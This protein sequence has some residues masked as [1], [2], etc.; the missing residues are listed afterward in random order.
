MSIC[1]VVIV[2]PGY[3]SLVGAMCITD[4]ATLND[5]SFATGN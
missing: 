3:G 5:A 1:T 4:N 2:D